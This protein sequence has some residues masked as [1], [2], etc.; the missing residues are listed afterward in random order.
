M[1]KLICRILSIGDKHTKVEDNFK[2][3]FLI[4][5]LNNDGINEFF[6][7]CLCLFKR[8]WFE[9]KAQSLDFERALLA[10][11]ESLEKVASE[12]QKL[13]HA[14]IQRAGSGKSSSHLYKKCITNFNVNIEMWK[15]DNLKVPRSNDKS[16]REPIKQAEK[17]LTE[18]VLQM[19]KPKRMNV[20][21][22]GE[23]FDKIQAKDKK[24]TKRKIDV[25]IST[26]ENK[27]N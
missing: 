15:Y 27:G 17:I 10:L 25:K 1:V 2:I 8:L 19:L 4:F 14:E 24:P 11:R 23:K 16:S 12:A 3:L 13:R 6:A 7:K 26:L 22:K 20:L 21:I 5:T 9:M 18:E